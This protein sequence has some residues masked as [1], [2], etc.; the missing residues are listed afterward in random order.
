[1]GSDF[2][3]VGFT[4]HD[5]AR[6][7]RRRFERNARESGLTRA[8][9][10]V[11]ALLIVK[12]GVGQSVLADQ[13]DIEPITL[14]RVVDKLEAMAMVERRSAPKDKRVRLLYLTP[15]AHSKAAELRALA[16]QTREEAF[17]GISQTDRDQL[18][19]TLKRLRSNL[20]S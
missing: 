16:E 11:V 13:M 4:L 3:N 9:W 8:Q 12:D 1:M 14:A 2:S 7:Y 18:M 17:S 5:V 10:H 19:H 6:L 20:T 15:A